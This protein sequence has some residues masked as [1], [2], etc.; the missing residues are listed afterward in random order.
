MNKPTDQELVAELPSYIREDR[1]AINA[2]SG[3]GN[4][5]TTDLTVAAGTTSLVVGTDLGVYGL[6][7]VKITGGAAVT[8]LT[9]TGGTEGQAKIFIFQDALITLTDGAKADGKFYLNQLPALSNFSPQQD[10]VLVLAN[11]GG[12]GASVHGYWK[13]LYRTISVK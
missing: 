12:D 2:V 3:A 10:D 6:E 7:I 4:V 13:E 5:G 9:I 11:I 8:L 1:V